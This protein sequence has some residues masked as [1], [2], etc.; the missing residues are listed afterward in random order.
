[1]AAV[2]DEGALWTWGTVGVGHLGTTAEVQKQEETSK[3]GVKALFSPKQPPL[4]SIPI[5]I[6]LPKELTDHIAYPTKGSVASVSCGRQHT[7][8]MST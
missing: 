7:L 5:Q 3:K 8:D 4:S 2:S 1:M 6:L